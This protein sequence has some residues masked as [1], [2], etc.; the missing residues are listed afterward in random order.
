MSNSLSEDQVRVLRESG[1]LL[2][3]E[4]AFRAG[5]LIVAENVVTGEKRVLDEARKIL[6]ESRGLLKG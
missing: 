2:K 6:S 1:A 4:I 3:N 5:D